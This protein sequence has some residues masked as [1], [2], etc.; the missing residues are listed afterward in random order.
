MNKNNLIL[1]FNYGTD[2]LVEMLIKAGIDV[3]LKD[4][5]GLTA[6]HIGLY[7]IKLK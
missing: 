6:L 4:K 2:K 3:N 7:K 1:A 5:N